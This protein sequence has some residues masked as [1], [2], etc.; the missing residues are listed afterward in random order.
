MVIS[1]NDQHSNITEQMITTA[2]A[3]FIERTY[4]HTDMAER[5]RAAGNSTITIISSSQ[6]V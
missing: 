6:L 1:V 5:A 3:L 4:P 2:D